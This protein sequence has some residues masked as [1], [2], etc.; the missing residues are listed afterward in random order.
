MKQLYCD[1]CDRYFKTAKALIKH[2]TTKSHI[3]NE[4]LAKFRHAY[5]IPAFDRNIA[6]PK[7]KPNR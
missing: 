5:L 1:D 4:K 2:V 7:K 6:P 3:A